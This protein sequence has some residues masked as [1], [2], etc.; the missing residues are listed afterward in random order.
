MSDL[1]NSASP[2]SGNGG[3]SSSARRLPQIVA[4][5]RSVRQALA[6][7]VELDQ[8]TGAGR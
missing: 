7:A 5:A 3:A 2:S 8:F 1:C 6:A 4:D